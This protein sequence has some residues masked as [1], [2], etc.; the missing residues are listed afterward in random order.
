MSSYSSDLIKFTLT[1]YVD[2]M[3]G[4][5]TPDEMGDFCKS[6]GRRNPLETALIWKSDIDKAIISLSD[7]KTGW[8]DALR[9]IMSDSMLLQLCR[10]ND[11]SNM[12]RTLLNDCILKNCGK[13][14]KRTIYPYTEPCWNEGIITRL[15]KYLNHDGRDEKGRF[16]VNSDK[17]LEVVK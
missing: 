8:R 16:A 1:H 13:E 4:K 12:Q 3:N 10:S 11:I 7:R 15:R 14:C 6:A 5:I 2:I 9:N 17:Q